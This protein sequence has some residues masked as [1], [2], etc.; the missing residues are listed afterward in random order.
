MQSNDILFEELTGKNGNIGLITLNRPQALNALNHHMFKVMRIHLN[1][2]QGQPSIKAVLIRAA[3]GRAFCA[4]G[5][6]KSVYEKRLNK[7]NDVEDFFKDEYAVNRLI[8]HYPKPYIALLNGITMGGGAGVSIHGSHRIATE[9][10]SF[11]MPETAIGFFPDIGASYFLSRVPHKIGFYLGL[12]GNR[13]AYNDVF[14]LGLVDYVIS[15]DKQNQLIQCLVETDLPSKQAVTNIINDFTI[16]V[17]SGELLK[18]KQVIESCFSY[19][20]VEKILEALELSTDWCKQVANTL[21]TKS[22]TSL[23]VTLQELIR[24]EQLDFD[25]CMDMEYVMMQQ[26]LTSYDFLEGVRAVLIEKD[27][28]PK[29]QPSHLNAVT[30]DSVLGYFECDKSQVL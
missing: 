25:A 6:V 21:N 30:E 29:W 19:P 24:G 27:K 15:S 9:R 5:D 13:I 12:S 8:Y 4:G 18:H 3:E 20:S 7:A 28:N 2:W 22:P 14:D 10:M 17:P 23:K 1:T 11:A 16:P 26:F